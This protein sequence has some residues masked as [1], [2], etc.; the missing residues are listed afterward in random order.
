MRMG[1]A[2]ELLTECVMDMAMS[3]TWAPAFAQASAT[4]WDEDGGDWR[5]KVGSDGC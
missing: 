2:G 5:L 4:Q 3:F 1:F